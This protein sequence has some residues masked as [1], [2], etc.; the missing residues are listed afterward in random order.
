[1]LEIRGKCTEDFRIRSCVPLYSLITITDGFPVRMGASTGRM[2]EALPGCHR[3]PGFRSA[4]GT[5]KPSTASILVT[6]HK[7]G[8][9]V[10]PGSLSAQGTGVHPGRQS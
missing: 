1:M 9:P 3:Q 6:R 7:G 8:P 10:L 2:T 4:S 5:D